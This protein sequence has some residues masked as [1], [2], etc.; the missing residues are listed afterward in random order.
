MQRGTLLL[1]VAISATALEDGF[2][3]GD[4]SALPWETTAPGW[5][6]TTEG[7]ASGSFSAQSGTTSHDG[8]SLLRLLAVTSDGVLSFSYRVSSETGYDFLTFLVDG[9]VVQRW[10]GLQDWA[11]FHF[12][13]TAGSHEFTWAYSKDESESTGEDA[14]WID[15]LNLP[16]TGTWTILD[17]FDTLDAWTSTQT[18]HSNTPEIDSGRALLEP[19]DD[20]G[21][22]SIER[23]LAAVDGVRLTV[24]REP[25][26]SAS[27]AYALSDNRELRVVVENDPSLA[28]HSPTARI[29]GGENAADGA[30]PWVAALANRSVSDGFQA[31]FCGGS[32]IHPYWVLTA[33]HCVE[34]KTADELDV[35]LNRLDLTSSEGERI[36][37]AQIIMHPTYNP[38][39]FEGD[40]AL[41]RLE[42]PSAI[43]PVGI[44][45]AA[46]VAKFAPGEEA[47]IMGWGALLEDGGFPEILQI[48]EVPIVSNQVA[49][50]SPL[51]SGVSDTMLAAG[52]SEGGTDSCQGDSGGPLVVADGAGWLQAGVVSWG[53]GCARP[54]GYGI[55]TRV[56]S[57]SGW[58]SSHT[59]LA[60]LSASLHQEG[61]LLGSSGD[62]LIGRS[63][64]IVLSV[65]AADGTVA[66]S[67]NQEEV[68]RIDTDSGTF[69]N[70]QVTAADA[71]GRV[72]VDDLGTLDADATPAPELL[73]SSA[74]TEFPIGA[75]IELTPVLVGSFGPLALSATITFDPTQL[76]FV[77]A[78]P[79]PSF[80]NDDWLLTPGTGQ[81]TLSVAGAGNGAANLAALQFRVIA[82]AAGTAEVVVEPPLLDNTTQ[83]AGFTAELTLIDTVPYDL[84]SLPRTLE[85]TAGSVSGTT[86]GATIEANEPQ[87]TA[88]GQ[89]ASIWFQWTAPAAGEL[90]LD[91]YGSDFDTALAVYR[92]NAVDDLTLLSENDDY[93]NGR[94]SRLVFPVGAGQSVRIA[95]DH[96]SG[97]PG[98][99][100][101]NYQLRSFPAQAGGATEQFGND[102][103]YVW[104]SFATT[105]W[106]FTN[107]E[108]QAGAV[109]DLQATGLETVVHTGDGTLTFDVQTSSEEGFDFLWLMIDEVWT[110]TWSG[111]TARQ[112]VSFPI[113]AGEHRFT[114]LYAKDSSVGEGQDTA[115]IDTVAFPEPP[116][117]TL[118]GDPGAGAVSINE[119]DSFAFSVMPI[120]LVGEPSYSWYE[121]GMPAAVREA[122]YTINSDF[123]SVGHPAATREVAVLCRVADSVTGAS[124][125]ASWTLTIH[126]VDRLPPAPAI[127]LHPALP[128]SEQAVVGFVTS[129]GPDPDGD[130]ILHGFSWRHE[131]ATVSGPALVP[132]AAKADETWILEVT[133]QTAPY[134]GSRVAGGVQQ[135]SVTF[136]NTPPVARDQLVRIALPV[137]PIDLAGSDRDGPVTISV[138]EPPAHGTW[139]H[140]T[141]YTS[142]ED[143]WEDSM[144]W[145]VTDSHGASASATLSLF[146]GAWK[147]NLAVSPADTQLVF[148]VGVQ[149]ETVAAGGLP[150]F[151]NGSPLA[152]DVRG[153]SNSGPWSLV[154][155]GPSTITWS[156]GEIPASG[157]FLDAI[158]MR[159]QASAVVS[160][161]ATI[162]Q[163]ALVHRFELQR[164]WNYLALPFESF[165]PLELP[166][167]QVWAGGYT[168]AGSLRAG[169]GFLLF[170]ATAGS[171][172]TVSGYIPA[173]APELRADWQLAGP[174]GADP[175]D[176]SQAFPG[177]TV[178][179]Q[180]A[181]SLIPVQTVVPGT[182]YWV[183]PPQGTSQ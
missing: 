133:A 83:L 175:V 103:T 82:A 150:H 95:L 45:S 137:S 22:A 109:I 49:N 144:V 117:P 113:S 40:L 19:L 129:Q 99:Y 148:G 58:I 166:G 176:A 115:W 63:E 12:P 101:L 87:H 37:V 159:L 78:I 127:H 89:G 6:V 125:S 114:W 52:F 183:S 102:P 143:A 122:S 178:W 123:D 142:T 57:F 76:A 18:G 139:H 77:Q 153:L 171:E 16:G 32:L 104:H 66:V 56:E 1:L 111:E 145:R 2:E 120:G 60:Q 81:I 84:F 174:V 105:P 112:S 177:R 118:S 96:A 24:D 36:A 48:A 10:S 100:V 168:P 21:T 182:G 94:R 107:A 108:A 33:A 170:E 74:Q 154:V 97:D 90:S 71:A 72:F 34:D 4:F 42:T 59:Q 149:A 64:S 50:D 169:D 26:P 152:S 65:T 30:W 9:V 55:Y 29:V 51:L 44:P 130:T 62:L 126:D 160:G 23:S 43:A 20:T 181:N 46:D 151:L 128:R 80:Y 98:T 39:T 156:P 53:E 25:G 5:T 85:A 86:T 164:G 162:N 41:L 155:N 68:W 157:L 136:Q 8:I 165:D 146:L 54:Q 135:S 119:N 88:L 167:A 17:A 158:D 110:G 91:T 141:G 147:L 132:P 172:L 124:T 28:E 179:Q 106:S 163:G 75:T 140:E 15:N 116:P 13:I 11:T 92:G 27:F 31:H 70:V 134:G 173:E 7:I 69:S 180:Q 121:D 73:L 79:A 3:S 61:Q 131:V 47:T 35:I 138:V 93:G 14:A 67:A 38:A 161:S